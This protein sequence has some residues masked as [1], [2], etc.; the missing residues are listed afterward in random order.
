MGKTL[1]D[2]FHNLYSLSKTLRF[3]LKPVDET[4]KFIKKKGL[5]QKDEEL[6]EKY[7]Q[8]KKIIDEYHK[9]FINRSLEG[10]SFKK[11]GLNDFCKMYDEFKRNKKKYY[12]DLKK[13]QTEFRKIVAE[14]FK[15]KEESYSKKV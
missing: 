14:Q 4:E 9:D 7:K 6:A 2:D 1:F 5:L 10:F 8:A 15:T 12:K 3:A 11:E 13:K